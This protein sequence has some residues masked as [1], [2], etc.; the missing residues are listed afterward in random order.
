MHPLYPIPQFHDPFLVFLKISFV[1]KK[2]VFV[3]FC[4]WVSACDFVSMVVF[5]SQKRG[6]SVSSG[7]EGLSA[8]KFPLELKI[9]EIENKLMWVLGTMCEPS[10]IE[11]VQETQFMLSI[12]NSGCGAPST[13]VQWTYQWPHS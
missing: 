8:A 9:Q 11:K 10:T 6:T 7:A 13:G 2:C 5:R 12:Y 1:L 4:M 3:C